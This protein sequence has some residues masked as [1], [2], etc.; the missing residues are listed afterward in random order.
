MRELTKRAPAKWGRPLFNMLYFVD[1]L[2]PL[3]TITHGEGSGTSTSLGLYDLITTELNPLDESLV[4][5]ARNTLGDLGLGEEWDDGDA[6]VTTAVL[7][8]KR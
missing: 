3:L 8:R 5:L 2:S 6:G 4:R 1:E 7:E